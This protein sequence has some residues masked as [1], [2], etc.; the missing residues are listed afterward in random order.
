[1]MSSPS[2]VLAMLD[3]L[4]GTLRAMLDAATE[5]V[6]TTVPEAAEPEPL[7][8]SDDPIPELAGAIHPA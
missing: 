6:E 7:T 4:N 5:M 3:A 8:A 1:M 2:S